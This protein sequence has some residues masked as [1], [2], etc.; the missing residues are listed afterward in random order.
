MEPVNSTYDY[1][2]YHINIHDLNPKKKNVW[3]KG[4]HNKIP[5]PTNQ[6]NRNKTRKERA[7]DP[8][9]KKNGNRHGIHAKEKTET[10]T[11][12]LS[13]VTKQEQQASKFDLR[14]YARK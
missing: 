10:N 3:H 9:L 6:I 7:R 2:R 12:N 8:H 5:V 13:R 14:L 1:F 4:P 11:A